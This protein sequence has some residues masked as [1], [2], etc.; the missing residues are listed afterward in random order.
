[1]KTEERKRRERVIP[2][3]LRYAKILLVKRKV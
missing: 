3:A 1:M 2:I